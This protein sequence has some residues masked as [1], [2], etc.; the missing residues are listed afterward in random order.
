M[1]IDST[2]ERFAAGLQIRRQVLGTD[3]VDRSLKNVSEFSSP[4]QTYVTETC[5]GDIWS[6][7]DIDRRTRSLL[8]LV[9]L[10]AL[11]RMHEFGVHVRGAVAN[12][13][14]VDEIKGALLQTA[15]YC[16]APAA[17]ESFRIAERVLRE[18]EVLDE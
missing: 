8:N 7:G 3:H 10:T 16:G 12:G 11:N 4:V 2:S 1:A 13:C 17:L 9:M 14:T 18:I 6:R 15:A 5:W